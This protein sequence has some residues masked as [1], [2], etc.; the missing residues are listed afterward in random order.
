MTA[1]ERWLALFEGR[2]VDRPPCDYW[3]TGEVTARLKRELGCPGDRALWQRLGIDKCIHLAPRHPRAAE[4]D[5]HLQ[6][7][8]SIWGIETLDIGYGCV[9]SNASPGPIPKSGTSRA[10][11]PMQPHGATTPSCVARMS[12]STFTAGCAAWSVR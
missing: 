12:P 6:S 11:A 3:A 5:W 8:F 4:T 7:L 2:P 9:T 1:R 10:S